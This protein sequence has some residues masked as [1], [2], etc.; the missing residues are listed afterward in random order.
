MKRSWAAVEVVSFRAC[1]HTHAQIAMQLPPKPKAG[2]LSVES[3]MGHDALQTSDRKRESASRR[4]TEID[5]LE[6]GN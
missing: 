3:T 6:T 2:N 4:N 5:S 1:H